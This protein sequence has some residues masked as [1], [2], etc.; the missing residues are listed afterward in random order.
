MPLIT[1][2]QNPMCQFKRFFADLMKCLKAGGKVEIPSADS[3][4]SAVVNLQRRKVS[5]RVRISE[6][7]IRLNVVLADSDGLALRWL[8]YEH[9]GHTFCP[10]PPLCSSRLAGLNLLLW[11]W[12]GRC[13][14]NHSP[15]QVYF[16]FSHI[17]KIIQNYAQ[18]SATLKLARL[19]LHVHVLR[20]CFSLITFS[21]SDFWSSWGL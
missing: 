3:L 8:T 2:L 17:C 14:G 10:Q 19:Q 11:H 9:L 15:L 5:K 12:P 13:W 20:L 16:C 7:C 4:H 1:N 6:T 21:P 18:T